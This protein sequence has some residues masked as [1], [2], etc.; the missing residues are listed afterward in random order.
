MKSLKGYTLKG[1]KDQYGIIDVRFSLT[2]LMSTCTDFKEEET[3]LQTMGRWMGVE[4]DHTPKCHPQLVGEGIEY[5]WAR[6][7]NHFCNILLDRK[8]GTEN[9]KLCVSESLS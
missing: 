9:F 8:R 3:I 6:C 4:V 7:K 2:H 5:T 1:R